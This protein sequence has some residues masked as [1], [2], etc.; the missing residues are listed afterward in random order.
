MS[1]SKASTNGSAIGINFS[2]WG[3]CAFPRIVRVREDKAVDDATTVGEI[4]D[5]TG[6]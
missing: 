2:R 4:I 1:Y 6:T 5:I 3:K